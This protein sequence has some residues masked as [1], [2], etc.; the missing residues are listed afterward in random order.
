MLQRILDLHVPPQN[1]VP[2]NSPGYEMPIEYGR[3]KGTIDQWARQHKGL[4]PTTRSLSGGRPTT[5][6]RRRAGSL[7]VEEG[8]RRADKQ[9]DAATAV[10]R[11]WFQVG[12]PAHGKGCR[13][14]TEIALTTFISKR[15]VPAVFKL[16]AFR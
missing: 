14:A 4:D 15:C 3:H 12:F 6:R 9:R 13:A 11:P 5:E 2:V 8:E 1:A 10:H 7:R 16:P